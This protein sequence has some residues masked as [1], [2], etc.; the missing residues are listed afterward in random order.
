MADD[1]NY[2]G[3]AVGSRSERLGAVRVRPMFLL[4]RSRSNETVNVSRPE[5]F[6]RTLLDPHW[7]QNVSEA[8]KSIRPALKG[9]FS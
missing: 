1:Q 4:V 7:L 3:S 6:T 5:E 8:D 9:I 2:R